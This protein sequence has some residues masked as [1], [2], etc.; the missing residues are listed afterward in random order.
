MTLL[1]TDSFDHYATADLGLK[2]QFGNPQGGD[3]IAVGQG[4]RGGNALQLLGSSAELGRFFPTAISEWIIG[5]G[6]NFDSSLVGQQVIF[7]RLDDTGFDVQPPNPS[8]CQ[9]S[10][11]KETNETISIYKGRPDQSGVLLASGTSTVVPNTWMYLEWKMLISPSIPSTYVALMLNENPE[12]TLSSGSN[13]QNTTNLTANIVCFGHQGSNGGAILIDDLYVSNT[14]GGSNNDYLGTIRVQCQFPNASGGTTQWTVH[15]SGPNYA[16]V[17][18]STP[19]YYTSYIYDNN[20]GDTDLIQVPA[21]SFHTSKIFGVQHVAVSRKDSGGYRTIVGA[22]VSGENGFTAAQGF[23]LSD[24]W[25][26]MNSIWE[27]DPNTSLNWDS[28][29]ISNAQFGVTVQS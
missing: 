29:S 7:A 5:F 3:T 26:A 20:V 23:F 25:E 1:F 28:A 19:D 24:A 16:A 27:V 10:L 9:C 22:V 21:L 17:N 4:R 11:V 15:P 18:E 6:I 12:I 13:S 14:S 8:S 2:W